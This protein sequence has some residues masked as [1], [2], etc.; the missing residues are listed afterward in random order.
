MRTKAFKGK[1]EIVNKTEEN[2]AIKIL[3]LR[4]TILP[5]HRTLD[6]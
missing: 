5:H 1:N 6:K 3:C 2:A 4:A